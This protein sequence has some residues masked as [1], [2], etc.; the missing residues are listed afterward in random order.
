MSNAMICGLCSACSDK[1]YCIK[2][3][4]DTVE[5]I[6]VEREDV[7]EYCQ[8]CNFSCSSYSQLM[9]HLEE[10]HK[11]ECL[12]VMPDLPAET[13]LDKDNDVKK[14][15]VHVSLK[16]GCEDRKPTIPQTKEYRKTN[17]KNQRVNKK[18]DSLQKQVH[19]ANVEDKKEK[20]ICDQCGS[21]AKNMVY[22]KK[23]KHGDYS[24]RE[25]KCNQPGRLFNRVWGH[26]SG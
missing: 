7:T 9:G 11:E 20:E 13:D 18:L 21:R 25:H 23:A 3:A 24:E 19:P 8:S 6:K 1:Q 5:N 10:F 4:E 16:P 15:M 2:E 26:F 14:S 17:I 12:T 22:H